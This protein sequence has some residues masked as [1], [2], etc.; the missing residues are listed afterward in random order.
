[1]IDAA[2]LS[3]PQLIFL[4]GGVIILTVLVKSGVERLGA[5]PL[6]GFI[7]LGFLLN[8]AHLRF[9]VLAEGGREL[10]RLL[11]E[12]GV[13][14]LMFR[15]GLESDIAGLLRQLRRASFVWLGGVAASGALGYATAAWVLGLA[16]LPSLFVAIAL[17][18]TSV[19]V[20]VALWH[21]AGAL[22][23]P[24]GRLLLVL[25]ELDDISGILLMALLLA[26]APVLLSGQ[27]EGVLLLV[28]ETGGLL[29][30][31]LAVFL[32]WCYAFAV[33]FESRITGFFRRG[34]APPAP[35]LVVA[36]MGIVIASLAGMLGLSI[37][38]GAFFA[39]LVF[40]RDPASDKIDASFNAL[41]ELFTP[42]FFVG[43]GLLIDPRGLDAA[44]GLGLALLAAAVV[45]KSL[46]HGLP[47]FWSAGWSGGVLVGVSMVPRA[48]IAMIVMEQGLNLGEWAVPPEVYAAMVL[49][50]AATC[51]ITPLAVRRLL[52][53]WPE[54]ARER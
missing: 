29:L 42:F 30:L 9:D 47:A 7:A 51:L 37:A 18:A 1:M 41:Y 19:G 12:I 20:S 31:K 38:V 46:G 28:A 5:P 32:L 40:S 17:T 27:G 8:L 2:A 54:V 25:A 39:G 4:I 52:Q 23:S 35:M 21:E 34:A 26:V 13:F 11:A 24:T 33:L 44:L 45:G 6:V 14:T 53:Q 36:G 15:I 48:E 49:V 16:M 50:S 22:G 3:N 43:I 10:F